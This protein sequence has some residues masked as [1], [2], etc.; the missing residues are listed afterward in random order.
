MLNNTV[1]EELLLEL[2]DCEHLEDIRVVSLRNRQLKQC[3]KC[4]AECTNLNIL[5][6]Q[7]NQVMLKDLSLLHSMQNLKKI[8]LSDNQL[9]SLPHS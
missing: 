2:T 4:L 7:S 8:D 9:E 1:T 5:Y 3:L 6:L